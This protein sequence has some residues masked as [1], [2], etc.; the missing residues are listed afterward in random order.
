[1]A[2]WPVILVRVGSTPDAALL[3]HERIHL[4]QQLEMGIV[5]FYVWYVLEFLVRWMGCGLRWSR[6]YRSI[7]MEREA[8]RHQNDL[9]YLTDRRAWA[10][11][12]YV[13]K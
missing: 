11:W 5:L 7:S 1:M 12:K 10:W 9:T 2:L 4:R 3:N 8:Y 6:A 13:S